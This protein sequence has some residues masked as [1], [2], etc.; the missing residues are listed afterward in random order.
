MP[1]KAGSQDTEARLHPM[2]PLVSMDN[3]LEGAMILDDVPDERGV[4]LWQAF[5]NVM[6]W[7]R[8][9]VKERGSLF[10][11][12]AKSRRHEA[13]V[14]AMNEQAEEREP[15]LTLAEVLDPSS[16]IGGAALAGACSKLRV[17]V[18]RDGYAGAALAFA[19]ATATAAPASAAR[20]YDVASLL[21]R[22]SDYSWADAW[23]RRT[24]DLARRAADWKHYGLAFI[25]MGHIAAE[26]GDWESAE[27]HFKRSLYSARRHGVWQVKW[28]ALHNLF[29]VAV[30]NDDFPRATRLARETFNAYG[31]NHPRLAALAHDVAFFWMMRGQFSRAL[32]VFEA[33]VPQFTELADRL[34]ALS[35]V[36]R[37]A[38]GAGDSRAFEKA[39]A[40]AFHLATEITNTPAE[41]ALVLEAWVNVAYGAASLGEVKRGVAAATYARDI[42]ARRGRE[43]ERQRAEAILASLRSLRGIRVSPRETEASDQPAEAAA[44]VFA[45][46]LLVALARA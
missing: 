33:L 31:P 9:P 8:T 25:G 12:G 1:G 40:S 14:E 16:G 5:R 34:L 19:I 37:A 15:L 3:C 21:R 30:T 20:A 38:G 27:G 6:L 28:M 18:E 44:D 43:P 36:V 7:S 39:W 24:A 22:R 32:P 29:T 35:N 42:A 2:P 41:N 11:P 13:I 4:L 46:D 45:K 17:I 26:R 23:Y 10:S